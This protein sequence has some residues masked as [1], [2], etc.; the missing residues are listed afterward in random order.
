MGFCYHTDEYVYARY[1]DATT[2]FTENK[3]LTSFA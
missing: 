3:T 1:E 2:V